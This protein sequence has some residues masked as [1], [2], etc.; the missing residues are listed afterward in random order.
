MRF[1]GGECVRG[2]DALARED[3]TS[4]E[5]SPQYRRIED[6]YLVVG[7]WVA[8]TTLDARTAAGIVG[9]TLSSAASAVCLGGDRWI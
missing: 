7:E 6:R 9:G 5:C 1:A 3:Q 8:G 4:S 2:N